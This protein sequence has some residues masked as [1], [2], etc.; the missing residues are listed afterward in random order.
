M[1]SF[2][3]RLVSAAEAASGMKV[4]DMRALAASDG[5]WFSS[6]RSADWAVGGPTLSALGEERA[7]RPDFRGRL[8]G[9]RAVSEATRWRPLFISPCH[10][11]NAKGQ[12]PELDLASSRVRCNAE[13]G[14]LNGPRR[15]PWWMDT[16]GPRHRA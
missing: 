15:G 12:H 14:P 16:Q 7:K 1:M 13:L 11:A 3:A 6:N 10:L 5:G 4:L 2:W 9:Q 8:S